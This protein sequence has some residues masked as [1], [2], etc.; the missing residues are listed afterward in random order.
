MNPLRSPQLAIAITGLCLLSPGPAFP[1]TP[2]TAIQHSAKSPVS[3]KTA[4]N[5]VL[6]APPPQGIQWSLSAGV[7]F[8]DIGDVSF[9]TG[10]RSQHLRLPNYFRDS[11]RLPGG[12]GD[13]GGFAL[14]TYDNGFV[15]PDAGTNTGGLFQGTTSSFGYSSDA[16]NSADQTLSYS[17]AGGG[18]AT[19]T[20]SSSHY[21]PGSWA[22][23]SDFQTGPYIE[24]GF[25]LPLNRH[26]SVG[27][28]LAYSWVGFDASNQTSTFFAT[29]SARYYSVGLTDTYAVPNGVI[30]PLAPYEQPDPNPGPGALPRIY[31][32][33]QRAASQHATGGETVRFFNRISE[34]LEVDVHTFN[35][36]PEFHLNGPWSTYLTVSGGVTMNIVPWDA[37]HTETLYVQRGRGAARV[38]EQFHD[39]ASGTEVLWGAYV[40]TGLGVKFGRNKNWLVE[41]FARWDWNEDL[42]GSVGPSEFSVD[43]DAFCAGVMVGVSF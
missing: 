36:G 19:S 9:Q 25:Q 13:A 1:G 5:V 4:K 12:A 6:P 32:T 42:E 8:K 3:S 27:A 34:S 16:Q 23:G 11:F 14:R 21:Q 28:Q 41:G 35:L 7:I 10:S 17:I 43:L 26:I 40:Q 30:L 2:S 15:G 29:Q 33:P 18:S 24:A 38:L 22:E 20:S 31:A 37:E 39:E